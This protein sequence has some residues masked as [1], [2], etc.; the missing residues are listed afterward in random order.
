LPVVAGVVVALIVSLLSGC[1]GGT[2][3]PAPS[4]EVGARPPVDAILRPDPERE[5]LFSKAQARALSTCMQRAGFSYVEQSAEVTALDVPRPFGVESR[6]DLQQLQRAIQSAK[7]TAITEQ[8]S[9]AADPAAYSLALD[10]PDD[11]RLQVQLP[12][13][14]TVG[15]PTQGCRA[16][17]ERQLFGA[18][19]QRRERTA[20]LYTLN[21]IQRDSY[22]SLDG[23]D[24]YRDLIEKWRSCMDDE[25]LGGFAAPGDIKVDNTPAVEGDLVCKEKLAFVATAAGL[26]AAAQRKALENHPG[27][28]ERLA[29]QQ[30]SENDAARAILGAS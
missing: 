23:N 3:N 7:A 2:A 17:A 20:N 12:D 27:V 18:D 10:G 16:E 6:D 30:Q 11:G 1:G 24:A 9:N 26:V 14:S 8:S 21:Q 4:G 13:G 5:N 19:D 25:H 15:M 28:L 29:A 22:A